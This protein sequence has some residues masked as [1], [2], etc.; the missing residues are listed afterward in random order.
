MFPEEAYAYDQILEAVEAGVLG[1][2]HVDRNSAELLLAVLIALGWRSDMRAL[3]GA[4]PHFPE[5]F[6]LVE[7]RSTLANLGYSSRMRE[8]PGSALLRLNEPALAVDRGGEIW[9][10]P[11]RT[12]PEQQLSSPR[13]VGWRSAVPR[14]SENYKLI[15]FDA[16][17]FL[18]ET[19][20]FSWSKDNL[21][22]FLPEFRFVLLTSFVSSC[23]TVVAAFG[24]MA[25]FD[26]VLPSRNL[27]TG[28]GFATLFFVEY[29]LRN[30]GGGAISR[31]SARL[32]Y[33]FGTVLFA[34]VLRLPDSL[35][36][37][38]PVAAQLTRLRQF[39]NLRELPGSPLAQAIYDLP[40][41]LITLT[42]IAIIAWPLALVLLAML[43]I[44]AVATTM[45]A[46]PLHRQTRRLSAAQSAAFRTLQQV[47]S[48]GGVANLVE[49]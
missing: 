41:A 15:E 44:L 39:Q 11:G 30:M 49:I 36:A 42:A 16:G 27:E 31:M 45:L 47:M 26:S 10:V 21:A 9:F 18:Q 5:Q 14:L 40:L 3:A 2:G 25:I 24:I 48:D 34:K 8:V 29:T 17:H 33:V 6:G 13:D 46:R 19:V 20:S 7:L 37:G 12:D 32:E 38:A 22:R 4:L 35:I 43:A 23:L 1:N 28:L